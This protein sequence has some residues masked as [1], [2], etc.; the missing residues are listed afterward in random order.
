MSSGATGLQLRDEP[1]EVLAVETE[2]A[3]EANSLELAVH[4]Q[5]ADG[6]AT[7]KT[8]VGG[9]LVRAQ[10]ALFDYPRVAGEVRILDHGQPAVDRLRFRGRFVSIPRGG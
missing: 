2:L 10:Q 8:Q 4:N 1:I 9:R 5:S 3:S 6:P 7:A